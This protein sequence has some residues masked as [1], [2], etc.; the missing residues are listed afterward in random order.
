MVRESPLDIFQMQCNIIKLNILITKYYFETT[1]I[2]SFDLYKYPWR[3][4]VEFI[5]YIKCL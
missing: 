4:K 2:N 1:L 5:F 3:K